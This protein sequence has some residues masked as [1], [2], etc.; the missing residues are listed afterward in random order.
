MVNPDK[1]LL[2]LFFVM[3]MVMK[4]EQKPETYPLSALQ[5][6]FGK[7]ELPGKASHKVS[8]TKSQEHDGVTWIDIQD[9]SKAA[10]LKVSG[11]YPLHAVQVDQCLQK[12]HIAQ[13]NVEDDYIFLLLYF[14]YLIPQENRIVTSQVSVFLGRDYLITVHDSSAPT[15]RQLFEDYQNP[16][17]ANEPG[18]PGHILSHIIGNL[19]ADV[20][21]LIQ[22]IAIELDEIE[23]NVFD[24]RGS[25]AFQI[26]QLRQKIMRLRRTLATQKIVLDELDASI[27]EF[28]G[29]HLRRYYKINTNM[30]RKL[31]ETVEEAGETIEIYKDADFTTSTEKTNQ[32]LAVLTLLFTLTIPATVIGTFY[33]MN[34]LLPGG[35][36][37]GS[38]TFLGDYTALKLI[39]G[40]SA[41]SALGMYAY[42]KARNWI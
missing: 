17:A 34:I 10:L 25:D 33:G 2:L 9:A 29:E 31:W 42:F 1:Q 41:I 12:G 11:D 20:S 5:A 39:S 19:L 15:L 40:V 8:N 4:K 32:I 38:W 16:S 18:S 27:D 22:T 36:E 14:P 7:K 23:D 3:I 37:S 35:I 6:L 30:S 24:D 26:G 13:I 28:S 21:S